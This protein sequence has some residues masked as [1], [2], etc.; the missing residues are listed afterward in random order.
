MSEQKRLVGNVTKNT[1]NTRAGNTYGA[2]PIKLLGG[3]LSL[4]LGCDDD[5]TIAY[6]DS[7]NLE[8]TNKY[9]TQL[10]KREAQ[11]KKE[12]K[13][14]QKQQQEIKQL[15]EALKPQ[16]TSLT[17]INVKTQNPIKLTPN[18]NTDEQLFKLR[19][20]NNSEAMQRRADILYGTDEEYNNKYNLKQTAEETS[21]AKS[22]FKAQPLIEYETQTPQQPEISNSEK[23]FYNNGTL[24]DM[25]LGTSLKK[26]NGEVDLTNIDI[27]KTDLPKTTFDLIVSKNSFKNG[28]ALTKEEKEMIN[29]LNEQEVD[30]NGLGKIT[31]GELIPNLE[32]CIQEQK[33]NYY[34]PPQST[35]YVTQKTTQN[36]YLNDLKLLMQVFNGYLKTFNYLETSHIPKEERDSLKK[37]LKGKLKIAKTFIKYI[38]HDIIASATIHNFCE[39]N[40]VADLEK[41]LLSYVNGSIITESG[42]GLLLRDTA[43]LLKLNKADSDLNTNYT[44]DAKIYNS[45]D[46]LPMKFREF[47]KNKAKGENLKSVFF[48]SNSGLSQRISDSKIMLDIVTNEKEIEKILKNNGNTSIIFE[49]NKSKDLYYAIKKTDICNLKRDE[50]GN[51]SGDLIDISDYGN[52]KDNLIQAA[53]RLQD[54][55]EFVP[56]VIIVHFVISKETQEKYKKQLQEKESPNKQKGILNAIKKYTK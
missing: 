51:I 7:N 4:G 32:E 23:M 20:K 11:L 16:K 31:V 26:N 40:D 9:E 6:L 56:R 48:N 46:E 10:K 43:G 27:K 13:A 5:N 12:Q 53:K 21:N 55:G 2:D 18:K 29:Y 44:K 19:K 25:P 45:I 30:I 17:K 36:K 14:I 54:S 28:I 24:A 15:K 52:E 33:K 41:M 47:V 22:N 34:Y 38:P 8:D 37:S 3:M 39:V 35:P 49:K 1:V 50:A 42:L